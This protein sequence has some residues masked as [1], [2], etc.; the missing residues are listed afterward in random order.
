MVTQRIV[1]KPPR[2]SIFLVMTVRRGHARAVLDVLTEVSGLGRAVGFRVPDDNLLNV[3]GIGA[4]LWQR[5]IGKPMPDKLHPFKE[6]VG[7]R[8]TAPRTPGDLLFH[9]RGRHEDVCFELARVITAA[10]DGHVDIVDEVH[11]FKYFDERDLLGFVD[12]TEN[13]EGQDAYDAVLIEGDGPFAG[14]SYVLVQ[15]YTHDMK[16][17]HA[18][19]VEE[20]ERVIGR[21]KLDDIEFS[22]DEKPTNSHIAL[23]DIQDDEGNDLDVLR[24][25]MAFGDLKAGVQ[26]TY[27]IAYAKDPTV[28]ERM[29]ENMFIGDPPGNTDRILDFSTAETGGLFFVPPIDTLDALD[30]LAERGSGGVSAADSGDEAGTEVAGASG[31]AGGAASSPP[32]GRGE[33]GASGTDTADGTGTAAGSGGSAEDATS[34]PSTKTDDDDNAGSLRIGS[35]REHS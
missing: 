27:F 32:A 14:G 18:V 20:Q 7:E 1:A 29:L 13:P 16:A 4:E 8:H 26:G 21:T 12:G 9:I 17:W 22:D 10:L 11:G 25:N 28:T 15:K 35:L 31:G 2:A 5:M 34:S 23:N 3:V 6:F 24:F 30:E 33:S 19:S